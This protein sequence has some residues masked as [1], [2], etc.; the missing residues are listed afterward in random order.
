MWAWTKGS[1]TLSKKKNASFRYAKVNMEWLFYPFW[2][3][4]FQPRAKDRS[5]RSY[6]DFVF[7]VF[8][9]NQSR[10]IHGCLP[11]LRPSERKFKTQKFILLYTYTHPHFLHIFTSL[12]TIPFRSVPYSQCHQ[13]HEYRPCQ[14]SQK[15]IWDIESASNDFLE[16]EQ[17]LVLECEI[18]KEYTRPSAALVNGCLPSQYVTLWGNH[19]GVPNSS[20]KNKNIKGSEGGWLSQS[21]PEASSGRARRRVSLTQGSVY[22]I[23]LSN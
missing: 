18:C 6:C 3:N 12:F 9:M 19:G 5:R 1:F 17:R 15:N 13:Y 4:H 11:K 16:G 8:W 2:W 10:E 23:S 7:S 20:V 22:M 14:C 21:L